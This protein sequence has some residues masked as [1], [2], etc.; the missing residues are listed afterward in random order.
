MTTSREQGIVSLPI[1]SRV[2]ET[3]QRLAGIIESRGMTVFAQNDLRAVANS[4]GLDMKP[5]VF[6]HI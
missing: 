5:M 6:A 3:A 2:A 4:V 1:R